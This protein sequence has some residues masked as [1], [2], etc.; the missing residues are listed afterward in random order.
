VTVA[1]D[2]SFEGTY[3]TYERH[4]SIPIDGGGGAPPVNLQEW[5]RA[6]KGGRASG[7]L[8]AHGEGTIALVG[9]A[10]EP[11]TYELVG[12]TELRIQLVGRSLGGPFSHSTLS[13]EGTA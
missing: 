6:G 4:F 13:R 9:L 11:F 12:P 8:G 5:G 1:T 2:G 7:I 3:D 10:G